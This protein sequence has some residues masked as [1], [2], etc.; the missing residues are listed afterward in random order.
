MRS[1]TDT[2]RRATP[3]RV[4]RLLEATQLSLPAYGYGAASWIAHLGSRVLAR[5]RHAS[6][7]VVALFLGAAA[8]HG[9]GRHIVGAVTA[10]V[11]FTALGWWALPRLED[12][13]RLRRAVGRERHP[14]GGL[15]VRET[16][17]RMGLDDGTIAELLARAGEGELTLAE[18]DQNNRMLSHI[19]QIPLFANMRIDEK[20]FRKRSRNRTRI[21]L[22]FGTLAVRKD[23]SLPRRF[24]NEVRALDALR[25]LEKVPTLL[26]VDAE[27]RVAYQ[28]FFPGRNLGSLMADAGADVSAQYQME[29]EY[30]RSTS[31][32]GST[33]RDQVIGALRRTVDDDFIAAI[34]RLVL[35]VHRSGVLLR[36]VKHGNVIVCEEGPR[37]CDFDLARVVR[38]NDVASTHLR[39]EER[40]R[41]NHLFGGDLLTPARFRSLLN[42]WI[43]RNP[44]L[45][46]PGVY[47]GRG[48]RSGGRLT[49]DGGTGKWYLIRGHLPEFR[50]QHV[51]DLSGGT[52][53]PLLEM[54]RTGA[55][56]VRAHACDPRLAE[57]ATLHHRFFEFVDNRN[58]DFAL[59]TEEPAPSYQGAVP[60]GVEAVALV[61]ALNTPYPS[62]RDA[63]ERAIGYIERNARRIRA[64]AIECADDRRPPCFP[65]VDAPAASEATMRL[66][67]LGFTDQ[68]CVHLRFGRTQLVTARRVEDRIAGA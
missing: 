22:T 31:P 63:W 58:Y 67:D 41:F 15:P 28:T 13:R 66:A 59:V 38:R 21:V 24:A 6:L 29:L 55:S 3:G 39:A 18:L 40:E 35:E 44:D 14:N 49:A 68:R 53:I 12:R 20:T 1:A 61:T 65:H 64:V 36:D 2:A 54:L 8:A 62:R 43:A 46:Y 17:R 48:Y 42:A 7:V 51:V 60:D 16:L 30:T 34:Q 33:V 19:G 11:G 57:V 9:S 4:G 27:N 23:Y 45:P 47:F 52:G 10:V 56:S 25:D 50:G 37:L 26:E 5:T 32:S